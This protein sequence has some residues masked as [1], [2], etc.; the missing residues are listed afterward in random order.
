[1]KNSCQNRIEIHEDRVFYM[2]EGL[3]DLKGLR[4]V[5]AGLFMGNLKKKRF[6]RFRGIADKTRNHDF[7]LSQ[8]SARLWRANR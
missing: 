5:R 4:I 8:T 3:P 6:E 2:P 1:M 7:T